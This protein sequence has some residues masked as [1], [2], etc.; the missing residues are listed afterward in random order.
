MPQHLPSS[1]RPTTIIHTHITCLVVGRPDNNVASTDL[2]AIELFGLLSVFVGHHGHKGKSTAAPIVTS[3]DVDVT[4]L[5]LL[6]KGFSQLLCGR[7]KVQIAHVK[8]GISGER[9]LPIGGNVGCHTVQMVFRGRN[10][11]VLVIESEQTVPGLVPGMGAD[12]AF[13][14]AVDVL[15]RVVSEKD[16]ILV[17]LL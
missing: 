5:A 15:G 12:G 8:L 11:F 13:D 17:S 6:G 2:L 3:N 14:A 16:Y 7:V 10:E 4:H 9:W 1:F